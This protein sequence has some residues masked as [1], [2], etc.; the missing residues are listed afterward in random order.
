TKCGCTSPTYPS[1]IGPGKSGKVSV[2]FQPYLLWSG[3][4]DE[5]ICV[6]SDDPLH[7]DTW[8][9]LRSTLQPPLLCEAGSAVMISFKPGDAASVST[10]LVPRADRRMV[11]R[12]VASES[13]RLQAATGP[14]QRGGKAA[15]YPL[16]L[17]LRPSPEPGDVMTRVR[18][19]T[20]DR[21]Y[22]VFYLQV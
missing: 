15:A 20:S 7:R 22:P 4:H 21:D 6:V 3:K 13:S 11:V 18:I 10:R 19:E 1:V 2:Q 17:K 12:K 16:S 9:T 14:A 8:L 5:R